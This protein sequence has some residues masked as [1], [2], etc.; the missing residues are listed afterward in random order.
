MR[1]QKKS[2]TTKTSSRK[3]SNLHEEN[4]HI[5]QEAKK[6]VT[7]LGKMLAPSCE[8]VLHDLT[9]PDN[10]IIAIECPLSGRRIGEPTTEI[11]LERIADPNFPDVIQNYANVFPD[12]RPVKSTS[13]G[14][15]N[16]AGK[17]IASICLN[18]DISLFSSVNRVLEQLT[19]T[20]ENSA[21]LSETL[22]TRSIDNLRQTMEKFAARY[23]TQ[24]RALLAEQRRELIQVI[25][26]DGLLQLRGAATIIGEILGIS[27]ASVYNII[28]SILEK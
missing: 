7:A 11:G 23:N 2:N 3:A 4:K 22:R 15:R 24:P 1:K 17:C 19:S 13:I 12:G 25:A 26:N 28:K 6:I 20:A 14:L 9:N 16:S 8:V 21:P 5:I 27:R 18:L 10:A